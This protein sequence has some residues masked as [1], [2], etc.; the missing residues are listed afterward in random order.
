MKFLLV[1]LAA[2]GLATAA[3]TKPNVL[4]IAIDDQNDWIGAFGGHPMAKTPNIDRLAGRGTALL[5]AQCNAPLCNP[6]RTSLMLGLRPS[7]TGI[8]GLSPWFRNVPAFKD[9]VTLPQ[10][11]KANGYQTYTSGKIYHHSPGGP[12]KRAEEFD[13]WGPDVSVGARPPKKLVGDTPMGNNPLVDWGVFPH[14]DEDKGDYKTA[15]WT[16]EQIKNA[17]KDKPFFIAAGFFLPHVPCYATQKWFDLYPDDDSVLPKVLESDRDDTPRFS[18]YLHWQLPEPRLSWLKEHHQWRNLVR[19]YLASTS[20]VDS[21]VGRVLTALDEAG[22]TDDTVIV[23][24]GDQGWHLGEKGIT[25][26]NT[27]WEED[28]RVPLIF[29]GPGVNKGARTMQPAELLDIYPTLIEL[30]GL[31]KRDDL[32]GLSLVP[33]IKDPDAKRERPAITTHNQGNHSVRSERWR[34]IHYA[35]GSE[36]LYDHQNDPNEWTNLAGNPEFAPI[37]AEHEKWLPQIDVPLAPGSAARILCYDPQTD[38]AVWEGKTV[39]RSDPIPE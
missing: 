2:C 5:N 22:L 11:F 33:Q 32:E 38:E 7:A 18:W 26:K 9:R 13:F 31:P 19:S 24:W 17:P 34:Y 8:Y 36:E 16:V 20:F 27:L 3:T 1:A 29:A 23:L 6:S 39:H 21:Q 35:D 14:K 30:C 28:A 15:S 25:G 4:F 37:V 12:A 10:H